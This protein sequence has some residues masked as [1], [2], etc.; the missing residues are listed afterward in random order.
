MTGEAD[1]AGVQK[2]GKYSS[3]GLEIVTGG[4]LI[5]GTGGG[6]CLEAILGV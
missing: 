1:R 4:V 5:R 2:S 3:F 6:S